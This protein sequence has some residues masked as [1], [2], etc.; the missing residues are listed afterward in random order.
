MLEIDP[1]KH[2]RLLAYALLLALLGKKREAVE[3]TDRAAAM[4]GI[5]SDQLHEHNEEMT[6]LLALSEL[7]E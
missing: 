1:P 6:K 3:A 5:N 2:G 7:Q 4:L